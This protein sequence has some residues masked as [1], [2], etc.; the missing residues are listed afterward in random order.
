VSLS[1]AIAFA[2]S[3]L[4]GVAAPDGAED[5]RWQAIIAVG[6]YVETNP[7]E[8]WQFVLRWGSH[9]DPDLRAAIATCLLE[10]LLEYHFSL[11]FPRIEAAATR[12]QLFANTVRTC[13]QFG[14]TAVPQNARRFDK[15]CD[16]LRQESAT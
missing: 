12:N 1:D 3:I 2:E 13:W 15:L 7:E 5:P 16:R 4:P 6:E 11:L 9:Q 10:H 14:Q 8:L